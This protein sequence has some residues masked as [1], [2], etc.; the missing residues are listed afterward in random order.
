MASDRALA[1]SLVRVRIEALGCAFVTTTNLSERGP[2]V[3]HS[4]KKEHGEH[5]GV[6]AMRDLFML[7]LVDV[8][9]GTERSTLTWLEIFYHRLAGVRFLVPTTALS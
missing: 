7:S 6:G 8:F 3:Q 5:V 2:S 9:L 1:L 4:R